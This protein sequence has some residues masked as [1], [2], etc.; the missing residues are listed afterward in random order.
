VSLLQNM[1]SERATGTLQVRSG[2]QTAHLYFLFGHLFHAQMGAG[3][4]MS[5]QG[6]AAVFN[7]LTW[8]EGEYAFDPK[9]K[10][11][12]E[13]TIK[14][15]TQEIVL[16]AANRGLAPAGEES[17]A[18]AAAPAPDATSS[19]PAEQTAAN[20]P[21]ELYPLPL[22]ALVYEALK[23]AFVDFPKLLR[24]LQIDHLT[25]YLRLAANNASGMVLLYRGSLMEALYDG[26]AVVSTGRSAF[27]LIKGSVDR[28]EGTLDVHSLSDDVVRGIYHLLTAPP[29]L[30]GLVA[31]FVKPD[32]LL[33]YLQEV[34]LTGPVIMRSPEDL[35]VILLQEGKL[36][37]AYTRQGRELSDRADAVFAL[38]QNPATRIEVR[39]AQ[40]GSEPPSLSLDEAL[41]GAAGQGPPREAA[42]PVLAAPA[43]ATPTPPAARPP[44]LDWDNVFAE[45]SAMADR[46]LGNRSKK[47]REALSATPASR[48]DLLRTIG[49][50]P[51]L[52]ILLI[53]QR[54][55]VTLA[56][57]MRAFVEALP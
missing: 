39:A 4:D 46:V 55:L 47:V 14:A 43:A 10:L 11:P 44:A 52:S 27:Q 16:E 37:G 53:D 19:E 35:G 57:D 41:S 33:A 26:G 54:K 15:S 34:R 3:Q 28:G 50:I 31:R 51:Q 1:Q 48:D 22:G 38:C 8:R 13:E 42:A 24:S 30:Q 36:L 56:E 40:P 12:P 5:V 6:E 45:L 20:V 32:E 29:Y 7:A 21:S 23:T 17:P 49:R 9:A 2:A 18:Y 25:G